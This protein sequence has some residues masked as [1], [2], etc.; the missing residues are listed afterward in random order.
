MQPST[1]GRGR[2]RALRTHQ[3]AACALRRG[4]RVGSRALMD[5]SGLFSQVGQEAGPREA[6]GSRRL[7]T[8]D[9]RASFLVG[10][11]EEPRHGRRPDEAKAERTLTACSQPHRP[12]SCRAA[13]K[14]RERRDLPRAAHPSWSRSPSPALSSTTSATSTAARSTG[15][16]SATSTRRT[17]RT[18]SASAARARTGGRAC[19]SSAPGRTLPCSSST[20]RW[21]VGRAYCGRGNQSLQPRLELQLCLRL[22]LQPRPRLP[23]PRPPSASST[24]A[25]STAPPT[26][27]RTAASSAAAGSARSSA[28]RSPTAATLR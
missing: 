12:S 8:A 2:A 14:R 22:E 21:R 23:P 9:R 24:C 25:S 26:P 7:P 3:A 17:A 11:G 18:G 16:T 28:A 15:R 13:D 4:E 5:V 19:A 20:C 27:S 6:G 1:S 10:L